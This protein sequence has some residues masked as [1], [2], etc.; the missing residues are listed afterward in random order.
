MYVRSC[1]KKNCV[2]YISCFLI[3]FFSLL[4]M[5]VNLV[6]PTILSKDL[7]VKEYHDGQFTI[8]SFYNKYGNL[9]VA[10][11]KGYATIKRL[12]L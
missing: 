8:T 6:S 11:D 2:K 1:V 3:V 7:I 10:T 5:K 9:V 12:V 4:S